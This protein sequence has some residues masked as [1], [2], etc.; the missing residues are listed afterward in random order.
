MSLD[1]YRVERGP[2]RAALEVDVAQD[3]RPPFLKSANIRPSSY[4]PPPPAPDG[5]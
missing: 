5:V 4:T 1:E 3:L 2:E